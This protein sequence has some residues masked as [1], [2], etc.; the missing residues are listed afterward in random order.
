MTLKNPIKIWS[1]NTFRI[2][3]GGERFKSLIALIL[4]LSISTLLCIGLLFHFSLFTIVDGR[5][6]GTFA[7]KSENLANLHGLKVKNGFNLDT[8][9]GAQ[10]LQ[11]LLTEF[12]EFWSLKGSGTVM[13][14]LSS[15]VFVAASIDVI[16]ITQKFIDRW[17]DEINRVVKVEASSV[18]ILSLS[19][20]IFTIYSCFLGILLHLLYSFSFYSFLTR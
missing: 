14:E 17:I 10:N 9:V 15:L 3:D 19:L 12:A 6:F 5:F 4:F 8:N 13:V 2:E 1:C 7:L 20:H 18:N 16:D 11:L